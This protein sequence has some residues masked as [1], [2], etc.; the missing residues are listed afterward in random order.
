MDQPLGNAQQPNAAD[1]TTERRKEA[2]DESARKV[3]VLAVDDDRS[4]LAYLDFLLTRA[5]FEVVRASNGIQ[6]I[7][8]LRHDPSIDLLVVDLAMPGMDGIETV[9][10]IQAEQP[11]PG[12]YTI[13]LTGSDGTETKLRALDS[14]LDDFL[15]KQSHDSEIVAKLRSAARRAVIERR[16]QLENEELQ[17]LALTDELTGIANRRALFR[18]A[19]ALFAEHRGMSVILFDLDHFKTVNDTHGH[20]TGDR[21]LAGVAAMLK[22]HTRYGDMIARYGGDE[23]VMLL[24]DTGRSTARQIASRLRSAL[25]GLSWNANDTVIKV[26]ASIGVAISGEDDAT[27]ADVLIRCDRGLYREKQAQP[28]VGP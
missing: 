25:R 19:E 9:R 1:E 14:G 22:Q 21:I 27:L 11:T 17:T 16:L 20:T 3:R 10:R 4:Y 15:T 24:P 23:F 26:E 12:L 28:S 18:T 13:L 2:A 8:R 5:G 7:E 6:A